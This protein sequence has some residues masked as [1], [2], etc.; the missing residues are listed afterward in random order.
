VH[1][2]G[3]SSYYNAVETQ[4]FNVIFN[5]I[6]TR[7]GTHILIMASDRDMG[8]GLGECLHLLN[9][10]GGSNVHSAMADVNAD[11]HNTSKVGILE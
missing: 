5:Q 3:A 9:I 8:Q 11:L 6:L 4:I 2:W 1:S 7:V 10:D